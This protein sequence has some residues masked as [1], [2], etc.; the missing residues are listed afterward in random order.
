MKGGDVVVE[1]DGNKIN[2]PYHFKNMV[3]ETKP[4]KQVPIKII[5][6]GNPLTVTVTIGELP[7]EAQAATNVETDNAL[8]GVSVQDLTDEYRQKMN[9]SEKDKGVIVSNVDEDSPALG[10]INKGDI[11]LEISHKPVV[12][13]K[14][15]NKIVSGIESNRDVLVLIVKNGVRQY[16]TVPAKSSK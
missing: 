13:T 4:G 1:Y 8:R 16:M 5:R 2:D 6:D 15:Y 9:I 12:N 14:E 10:I 11:I 3:A 7:V